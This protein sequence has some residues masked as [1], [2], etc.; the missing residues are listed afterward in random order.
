MWLTQF[1]NRGLTRRIW[2]PP[3]CQD[4]DRLLWRSGS[5]RRCLLLL[6]V[7][8]GPRTEP[9]PERLGIVQVEFR[10][11]EKLLPLGSVE[12]ISHRSC[13][14]RLPPIHSCLAALR[15]GHAADAD[16]SRTSRPTTCLSCAGCTR[17]RR[18]ASVASMVAI[19]AVRTTD[20]TGSPAKARLFTAMSPGQ[21]RFSAL[22]IITT[23]SR[24]WRS[25]VAPVETTSAGR[26]CL[27]GRSV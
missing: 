21:P 15:P 23:Q 14:R 20:G 19:L 22:V 2:T 25:S 24:P 7:E 11:E 27:V 9:S 16:S 17:P 3:R 6:W 10:L 12:E 13:R 1:Y 5:A 8:H 4:P 18:V 26:D